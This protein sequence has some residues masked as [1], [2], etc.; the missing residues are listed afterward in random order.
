MCRYP[1]SFEMGRK[2]RL[3]GFISLF[4]VHGYHSSSLT[5][6]NNGNG[7]RLRGLSVGFFVSTNFAGRLSIGRFLTSSICDKIGSGKIG[8]A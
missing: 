4:K 8:W 6:F 1:W 7:L 5:R 2:S 3:L